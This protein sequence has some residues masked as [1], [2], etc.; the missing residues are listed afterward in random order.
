M[1]D[2]SGH[3]F[4]TFPLPIRKIVGGVSQD[5]LDPADSSGSAEEPKNGA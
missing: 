4:D 3:W 1:M 5:D 2:Q